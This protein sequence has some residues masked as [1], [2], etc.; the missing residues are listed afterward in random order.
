MQASDPSS[1]CALLASGGIRCWGD[2]GYGQLGDGTQ[3]TRL[4]PVAVSG[5]STATAIGKS[6]THSCAVLQDTTVR[7]WGLNAW[8]QLGDGTLTDRWTPVAVRAGPGSPVSMTG[9]VAVVAGSGH[10]CARM[11]DGT[12]RCW[13]LN[14]GGQLGDASFVDRRF[15]VTPLGLGHVKDLTAGQRHTCAITLDGTARCWGEPDFGKLGAPPSIW[16]TGVPQFVFS[17]HGATDIAGGTVDT[18]AVVA[19]GTARCWGDNLYG[20]IGDGTTSDRSTPRPVVGLT[21]GLSA[22]SHTVCVRATDRAGNTSAGGSCATFPVVDETP[23]SVQTFVATTPSPTGALIVT[24]A[25]TFSEPVTG[26]VSSDFTVTGSSGPW[27]VGVT[28]SGTSFTVTLSA[29][30]PTNGSLILTLKA[31]AVTDAASNLGP[32]TAR[33][34][35]T[36]TI[37]PFNDIADSAFLVDIVWLA[38]EGIT[39]GCGARLYCP[40]ASV[41]RAEMASFLARTLDLSGSAPDAFDDDETSI[42]EPNINL[43]AREGIASGCAAGKFCPDGLV[44]REQMA[45]FLARALH[46]SGAAPDAFTDD[47]TSIHEPNINLVAREGIATGCGGTNYCPTADVTRGQMAAF[48]HRA[49]GFVGP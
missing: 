44:S 42:H 39:S 37:L 49:A 40:D 48:L 46:L 27:T 26:L 29:T 3:Q 24:Y 36:V 17:L 15:P 20:Q 35:P 10:T 22:G 19:D 18:C 21:G 7:C 45:S 34:A 11:I 4:T 33:A 23:P 1:T 13:G 8:G 12:V 30:N 2:N 31:A 16:S 41:T 5:I 14:V 28:G 25:L 47:E 38:N 9:A 6:H 32:T 43:I